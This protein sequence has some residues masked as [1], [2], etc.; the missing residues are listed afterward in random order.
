M[1]TLS[2]L[3]N[4]NFF[5]VTDMVTEDMVTVVTAGTAVTMAVVPAIVTEAVVVTAEVEV[6]GEAAATEEVMEVVMEV[7]KCKV[8]SYRTIVYT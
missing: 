6:T 2:Y 3:K 5:Q 1:M 7:K 8:L 4:I